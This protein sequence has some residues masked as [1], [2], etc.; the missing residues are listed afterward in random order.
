[1][2]QQIYKVFNLKS[3]HSRRASKKVEGVE[4]EWKFFAREPKRSPAAP[5]GKARRRAEKLP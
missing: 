2:V 5:R 1:M 3:S 4:R